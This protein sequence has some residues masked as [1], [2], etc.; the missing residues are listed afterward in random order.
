MIFLEDL[1]MYAYDLGIPK[2]ASPIVIFFIPQTWAI[3]NYRYGNWIWKK[4]NILFL[5]QILFVFYFIFKI[6]SQIIT[7]IEISHKSQ[8]GKGLHIRHMG[9]IVI[10]MGKIGDYSSIN[11]GVTVGAAGRDE[12]FSFPSIGNFVYFGTGSKVLGKIIIGDNVAIGANAVVTKSF[13]D[14]AVIGGVP[15][16][17]ISYKSSNHFI[18]YR[19]KNKIK[20]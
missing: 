10:G 9:N 11:N 20:N 17:L 12:K 5:K 18:Y 15:A 16:K 6:I 13:P 1:D 19:K 2:W 3:L 8:I 7:G 14:N 4:C